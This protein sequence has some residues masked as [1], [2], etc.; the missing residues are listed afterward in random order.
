MDI[1]Q[2]AQGANAVMGM[3]TYNVQRVIENTYELRSDLQK[4]LRYYQ[5]TW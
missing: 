2:A 1:W 5:K 4:R 3:T